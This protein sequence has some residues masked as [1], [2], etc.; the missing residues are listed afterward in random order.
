MLQLGRHLARRVR[1]PEPRQRSSESG[2]AD[3]SQ[4]P[5]NGNRGHHFHECKTRRTYLAKIAHTPNPFHL[6][7]VDSQKRA[8][9]RK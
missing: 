8:T 1:K 7:V 9:A 5:Y 6:P 4:N 3:G 2:K